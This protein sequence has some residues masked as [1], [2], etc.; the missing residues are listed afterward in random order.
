MTVKEK[1]EKIVAMND[2]FARASDG[3]DQY[4]EEFRDD[5]KAKQEVAVAFA[6]EVRATRAAFERTATVFQT[7][8]TAFEDD[9]VTRRDAA[10]AFEEEIERT[11]RAFEE[12]LDEFEAYAEAFTGDVGAK[13]ERVAAFRDECDAML[14]AFDASLEEFEAYAEA[15]ERDVEE[16]RSAVGPL[17]EGIEEMS[18]RYEQAGRELAQ[19]VSEFYGY[20][21]GVEGAE[22]ADDTNVAAGERDGTTE[23]RSAAGDTGRAEAD[24]GEPFAERVEHGEGS[25]DSTD[26]DEEPVTEEVSGAD[27]EDSTPND[28]VACLVCGE[29][30]QAI[31]ESHLQTHDMSMAAYKEEFGEDVP[32]YPGEE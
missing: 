15:F 4:T 5:V 9:V 23:T 20:D 1:R 28:M 8:A 27:A 12:T 18:E 24:L 6:D 31:T 11:R 2:E 25:T 32:L 13:Q 26:A 10:T 22:S 19:A 29:Y 14:A 17:R 30:Y 16:T 7:Y 21:D 3:F